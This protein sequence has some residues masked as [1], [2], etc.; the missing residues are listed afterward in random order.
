APRYDPGSTAPWNEIEAKLQCPPAPSGSM[1]SLSGSQTSTAFTVSWAVNP[2][3][4]AASGFHN[5][6]QDGSG[7]WLAWYTGSAASAT[8]YGFAGHTYNFYAEAYGPCQQAPGPG[9]PQASTTIVP[10]ATKANAFTGMYLL[11][12]W[13]GVHGVNSPPLAATAYWPGWNIARGLSTQGN[14]EGGYVVDGWG[15]VHAFGFAN[16][17]VATS[18]YWGGWDIARDVATLPDGSGGY[19]LDGWGGIHPFATGSNTMPPAARLSAYW[20]GWDI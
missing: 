18:A 6:V 12:G 9:S 2:G 16:S 10:G 14:G 15:G 7:P 17:S 8:F 19:V 11:D 3:S 4:V 13:G 5:W 1:S 20:S